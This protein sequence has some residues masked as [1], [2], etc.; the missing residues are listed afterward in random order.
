MSE[1]VIGW[2]SE[3]VISKS[4]YTVFGR[5]KTMIVVYNLLKFAIID[6]RTLLGTEKPKPS[7]LVRKIELSQQ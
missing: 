4:W 1:F 2:E 3:E 7:A 5:M 6:N